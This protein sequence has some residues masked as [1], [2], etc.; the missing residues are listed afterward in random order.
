[1]KASSRCPTPPGYGAGQSPI[2][3]P[4][5]SVA[6]RDKR[7]E[8]GASALA[9]AG[10]TENRELRTEKGELFLWLPASSKPARR[11][12][13][14]LGGGH[15][16]AGTAQHG[17]F[18]IDIFHRMRRSHRAT[19]V[20]AMRQTHGVTNLVHSF[21]DRALAIQ[22]RIGGKSIEFLAP[23]MRRHHGAGSSHLPLRKN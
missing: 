14:G 17:F 3:I 23:A 10:F 16:L 15:G 1:M 13:E 20:L 18:Q 8:P 4:M 5:P 19:V 21:L 22:F 11:L 7:P 2:S 9:R 12:H 6:R